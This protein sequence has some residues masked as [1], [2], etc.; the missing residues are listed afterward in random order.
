M[1]EILSLTPFETIKNQDKAQLPITAQIAN[2]KKDSEVPKLSIKVPF[3][4]GIRTSPPNN[5][6]I[7]LKT[8]PTPVEQVVIKEQP[9]LQ[10]EV[11]EPP[12]LSVAVKEQPELPVE[13]KVQPKPVE[14]PKTVNLQML[15]QNHQQLKVP[16]EPRTILK[17]LK[18]RP[19][20]K[21]SFIATFLSGDEVTK[22]F[23]LYEQLPDVE[24]Y[25]NHIDL[26]I[27]EF[28]KKAGAGEGYTP[29]KDEVVL[30]KFDGDYFRAVVLECVDDKFLVNFRKYF[31]SLLFILSL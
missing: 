27:S 6:K 30:A 21:G 17:D 4:A 19:L 31:F 25:F 26:T 2:S 13:V 18:V 14:A 8:V 12:K 20:P 5:Y 11:K 22:I 10:V 3:D 1:T 16:A 9:K 15:R 24:E 28:I 29:I 7:D 23:A